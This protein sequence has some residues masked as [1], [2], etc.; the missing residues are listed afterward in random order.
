MTHQATDTDLGRTIGQHLLSAHNV[1]FGSTQDSEDRTTLTR[2]VTSE[3]V[4]E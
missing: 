1:P 4:P 3:K 2:M